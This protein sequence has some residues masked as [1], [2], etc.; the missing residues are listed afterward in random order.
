MKTMCKVLLI[1][2]LGDKPVVKTNQAGESWARMRV[3]T[4]RTTQQDGLFKEETEW[5][6][7]FAFGKTADR[8]GKFLSKGSGVFIEGTL[9]HN[10]W[11]DKDG[12][13][14]HDRDVRIQEIHF[15]DKA[16]QQEQQAAAVPA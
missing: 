11:T 12:V 7:V 8:C 16:P 3:A 5:H 1:G 9:R 13:V 14:Q 15:L 6:T 4:H 2:R 10:E